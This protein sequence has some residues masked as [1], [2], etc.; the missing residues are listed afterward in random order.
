MAFPL[1][2]FQRFSPYIAE[3]AVTRHLVLLSLLMILTGCAAGPQPA[4]YAS[5]APRLDLR[6]YFDGKIDGWGIVQDRKGKVL[7]RFTVEIDGNWTQDRGR[8]DES[9]IWSDG[10]RE[11]RVWQIVKNGDHYTGTAGDVVGTA[12]GTAAGHALQ[13][14]YVLRLPDAQGGYD[15]RMD[16]WMW[17]IDDETLANRTTMKKFG[18]TF[19]EISI[20]FRKRR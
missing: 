13:W 17:L 12:T 8:L 3:H 15:M 18:I 16:D 7:R 10:T 19:A 6:R 9:F 1:V 2:R 14:S 20:F 5:E 11:K 4:D